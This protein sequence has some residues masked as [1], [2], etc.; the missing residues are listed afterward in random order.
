MHAAVQLETD[1]RRQQHGYGLP[2]H[3]GLGFDAAHAPTEHAQPID[4]G[5]VRIRAHQRVGIRVP[6]VRR[7]QAK[8]HRSQIFEIHLV[9]DARIGRHHAKILKRGLA[10]AQQDVALA[11]ALEFE[12]RVDPERVRAAIAIHLHRV[13][14]HQ[15]GRQ[16]RIG[17]LGVCAHGGQ[18]VAH[19]GEI[20]HAG[21]ARKILQQ[22]ARG[23]EAD[24]FGC[25]CV[26]AARDVFDIGG[27]HAAAVFLAQQIFQQDFG[28]KGQ[29]PDV[30]DALF[31]KAAQPKDAVIGVTGAQRGRGSE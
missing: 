22:H 2:E 9:H 30:A 12:Q 27:A 29:A 15:V 31:F 17:A 23:H 11:V 19:G 26:R 14:D 8:H 7:L 25:G 20:H 10:P 1:H 21:Y 18:R 28:G 5:G 4:H 16:Q 13:V 6:T 3:A 24:L